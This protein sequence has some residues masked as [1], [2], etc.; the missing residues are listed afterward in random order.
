MTP[1]DI[2]I[3]V[4]G[5]KQEGAF[6]AAEALAKRWSPHLSCLQ[7][8]ELPDPSSTGAMF[9][10]S[11]WAQLVEEARTR[12][13]LERTAIAKRLSALGA[14]N[15][16]FA[17][18]SSSDGIAR[19]V[20]ERAMQSDLTIMQRPDTS[21]GMAAFEAALFNSGRPVLL[22]PPDWRGTTIGRRILVA[23]SAK[24]EAARALADAGPFLEGADDIS[25]VAVDDRAVYE[26]DTFAGRDISTHLDRH[27]LK[28]SLHQRDSFGRT[29]DRILLDEARACGADLIVMGGYGHSRLREWVLGGVTRALISHC[30]LP[31][32]ISH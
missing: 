18:E 23:W 14:P 17:V 4:D 7:M 22:A 5:A 10:P 16:I 15:E 13:G 11:V 24:R 20:A 19:T 2:L 21:Q 25:V 6:V 31:I 26:G 12:A 27:G 29:T 9:S 3:V 1:K 28:V 30:P 8:I 32:L